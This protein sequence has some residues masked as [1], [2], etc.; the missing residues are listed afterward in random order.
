MVVGSMTVETDVV[1]IG[2]GPGGY[3]AAIRAA[4]LGLDVLVVER[5]GTLG[6]V[7]LQRGCIPTKALIAAS[8]Y[9]DGI[10]HASAFGVNIEGHSID[11]AKMFAWK[12]TIVT[13]LTS[14]IAGL[15][16][17]H[18]I[19]VIRGVGVFEDEHTLRVK[20]KSDVNKIKFKHA[21]ISTGSKPIELPFARFDEN[22]WSSA[23]ALN[24][25]ELPKRLAIIGGG[26]IGTEMATVFA[27]LG[28]QVTIIEGSER[29]LPVF[30][31]QLVGP[32]LKNLEALGVT[33]LTNARATS[34]ESGPVV[35]IN[36]SIGEE[37]ETI[38]ADK[39]LVVV[40]RKPNSQGI[41]LEKA[42]VSVDEHGFIPTDELMRTN[43]E[44]IYAIGD[45]QGQP[46]LAHKA[47]RQAKVAA[48]VI[49]GKPSAF[50]NKVV[51]SVVFNDPEM[52]S[53]GYTEA[54]AN[55]KGYRTRSAHFPYTALGK[56]IIEGKQGFVE[57]VADT[58][59]GIIRGIHAVGPHVSELA[60]EAALAI[61][62]GATVE[63][64][65]LTIHP[66]PTVSE[67]LVEAADVF[68]GSAI[69]IFQKGE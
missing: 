2:S 14:G 5:E 43:I 22:I 6:G 26:Y 64:L 9:A 53:V 25:S 62:L 13:K 42:G 44:H 57:I 30:E 35:R 66:H 55:A 56:A 11:I 38:E 12:Q 24:I 63:D 3:V 69:H 23:D 8:N 40:G 61:E 19:E 27:K 18:G 48:E 59:T 50:D 54:E 20:G 4:Q 45:V 52:M 31:P 15:F 33:I 29:I 7:C 32:V 37:G 51:P 10:K 67:G 1:I 60:G 16:A 39:L 68:L 34:V 21:I 41:G 65:S 28:S 58:D 36:Y 49:A 46:M 47:M 17:K